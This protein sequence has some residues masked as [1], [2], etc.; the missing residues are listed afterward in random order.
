MDY[1]EWLVDIVATTEHQYRVPARTAEEAGAV[2]EELF[3]SGDEG[4]IVASSIESIDAVC[5]EFSED[6]LEDE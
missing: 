6:D 1:R 2:A 5:G 4:D 3:D